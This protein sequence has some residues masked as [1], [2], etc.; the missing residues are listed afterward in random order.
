MNY[1]WFS[2][3]QLI[4]YVGYLRHPSSTPFLLAYHIEI[5]L[6]ARFDA[7]KHMVLHVQACIIQ[8][9]NDCMQAK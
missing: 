2:K 6:E 3:F 9:K 5:Q 1:Y 4:I 7:C 8:R